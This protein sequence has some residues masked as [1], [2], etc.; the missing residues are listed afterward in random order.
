MVFMLWLLTKKK[1]EKKVAVKGELSE[2]I[3]KVRKELELNY[4]DCGPTPY[5]D[6][7]IQSPATGSYMGEVG[8]DLPDYEE[9]D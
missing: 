9:D 4:P 3:E 7:F 1:G 2:L 6:L 5:H 8:Q